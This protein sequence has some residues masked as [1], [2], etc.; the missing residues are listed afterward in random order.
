MCPGPGTG[1]L[2]SV[3]PRTVRCHGDAR[4]GEWCRVGGCESEGTAPWQPGEHA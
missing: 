1:T 3:D 2:L 4:P